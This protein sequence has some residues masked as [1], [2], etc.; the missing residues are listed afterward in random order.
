MDLRPI[1]LATTSQYRLEAF[2]MLGIPFEKEGSEVDEYYEGRPNDPEALVAHLSKLKAKAVEKK[3]LN[4]DCVILGF[5]SVAFFKGEILEKP[6]S[7]EEITDR[8]KA[9]SGQSYQFYTGIC[10]IDTSI[11][12]QF[13]Y[14]RTVK[15]EIEMRDISDL[16]IKQYLRLYDKYRTCAQGFNPQRTYGASFI[17][18]ISGSYNNPLWG[19]PLAE[20]IEMLKEANN[21]PLPS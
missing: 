8:L 3:H 12:W 10:L 9:F 21:L 11:G 4:E 13:V 7:L 20:V 5:D 6:K 1:I 17:K 18:S 19:I 15:T 14:S 16:E 2:G